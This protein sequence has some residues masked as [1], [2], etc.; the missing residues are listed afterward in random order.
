MILELHVFTS[1]KKYDQMSE[2]RVNCLVLLF[3]T[4]KEFNAN[5]LFER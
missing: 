2:S 3:Y 1:R 5:L 4:V